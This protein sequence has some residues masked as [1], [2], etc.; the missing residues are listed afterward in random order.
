[1]REMAAN[2][3]GRQ[4]RQGQPI[5]VIGSSDFAKSMFATCAGYRYSWHDYAGSQHNPIEQFPL[6]AGCAWVREIS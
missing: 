5:G 1:M 2:L 3:W 6:A 4:V